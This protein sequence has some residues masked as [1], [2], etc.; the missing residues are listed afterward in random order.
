MQNQKPRTKSENHKR[1]PQPHNKRQSEKR[2]C[3]K[4]NSGPQTAKKRKR[5]QR[6]SEKRNPSRTKSKKAKSE[7]ATAPAPKSEK[8]PLPEH[9]A[10]GGADNLRPKRAEALAEEMHKPRLAAVAEREGKQHTTAASVSTVLTRGRGERK[11]NISASSVQQN[12]E[13]ITPGCLP[14]ERESLLF[15]NF[16]RKTQ[17]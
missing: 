6:T 2:T 9:R 12:N 1:Q 5:E 8:P 10:G 15:G 4:R 14:A 13:E 17:N 3:E 16:S 11:L 7:K